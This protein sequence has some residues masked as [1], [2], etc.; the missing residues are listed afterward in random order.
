MIKG[1]FA[2]IRKEA[3][4]TVHRPSRLLFAPLLRVGLASLRLPALL[5]LMRPMLPASWIDRV[6]AKPFYFAIGYEL[7]QRDRPAE[8]WRWLKQYLS[9][10]HPST[11]DYHIGA[12]C[13]YHGLGRFRDALDLLAEAN[14]QNGEEA[15]Q[16]NV[17]KL[18]FR[19]LNELWARHIGHTATLDYVI[20]LGIL[21]HRRPEHTILYLPPSSRV[22]NRFLLDEMATQLRVI[23]N[24]AH[25]PFDAS[26]LQALHYDYLGPRLPDGRTVYFWEIAAKTYQRWEEEGRG[27]LLT[28]SPETE[29]RGRTALASAGMPPGAWFVALHVREGRWDGRNPG[30]HGV[31]N[32]EVSTYLPAIAEITRRDGWVVRMGDPGMKPLPP[33]PNVVDYCHSELRADWLDVFIAARCRFMIGT[34]SGPAFIPPLYGPPLLLTNWWPPAQRPLHASDIFVPKLLRSLTDG[35]YLTL[36]ETLHEPF[37]YCHSRRYLAEQ[38]RV[39]IEDCNPQV[40]TGAVKEMLARSE[41]DFS[42]TTE[43]ADLRARADQIYRAQEVFGSGQFAAEF[44][45]RHANFIA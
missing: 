37:S 4:K 11:D 3:I 14:Q 44:L 27:P 28:L 30:I 16:H 7:L 45:Q 22:A 9:I 24:P 29:A 33:L 17:S 1:A 8:A 2:F 34:T 43:V 42:C 15:S 6:G 25:L 39:S 41:G 5:R 35:R 12:M 38:K 20:K 32:A 40:L 13:L 36:S 10:G 19:V 18:P 23:N 26:A 31:M 21:E